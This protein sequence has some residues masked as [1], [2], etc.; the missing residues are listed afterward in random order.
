MTWITEIL[1]Q[2][3]ETPLCGYQQDQAPASEPTALAAL[4]LAGYQHNE[5][6]QNGRNN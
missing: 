1:E 2:L 3:A 5:A 6:A 4:A